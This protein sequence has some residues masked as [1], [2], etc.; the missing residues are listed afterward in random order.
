MLDE[1]TN[2]TVVVHVKEPHD[3]YI[4]RGHGSVWGNPYTHIKDKTTKAQYI[5]KT[6]ED[7]ISKYREWIL[8]QPQ[9][10]SRLDELRGKRLA[11]WCKPNKSCHGDV[12]IELLNR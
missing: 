4:G 10:L 8:Q 11:C 2:D 6:R 5:T 3:I 12:L 1:F 7:A 9:L